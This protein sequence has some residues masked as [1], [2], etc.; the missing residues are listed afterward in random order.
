DDATAFE[1]YFG[2]CLMNG[3][4]MVDQSY[5]AAIAQG[6]VD[7][8]FQ[9]LFVRCGSVFERQQNGDAAATF[10]GEALP[11][12]QSG[13]FPR[14]LAQKVKKMGAV[15]FDQTMFVDYLTDE[16]G[17]CS[18]GVALDLRQGDLHVFRAKAVIMAMGY[19]C[20]LA[21]WYPHP[22][23]ICGPESTGDANAILMNHGIGVR[24]FELQVADSAA[25]FPTVGRYTMGMSLEPPNCVDA[26]NSEGEHYQKD[27]YENTPNVFTS[28]NVSILNAG[29][30]FNG[31][32]HEHRGA[33]LEYPGDDKMERFYR[34]T[35]EQWKSHFGYELPERIE[36]TP[37]FWSSHA[38]PKLD[39]T[40][41]TQVPGLY[42]AASAHVDGGIKES[43]AA[44]HIAG[45]NA[46]R[47]AASVAQAGVIKEDVDRILDHIYDL[48]EREPADGISAAKV[49]RSIQIAFGEGLGIMRDEAGM[50]AALEEFKRIRAEDLP[51]MRVGNKTRS[52]N[53]GWRHAI[54]AEYMLDV[55]IAVAMA[56]L[57]RKETR[58]F[59]VRTDYLETDVEN[60]NKQFIV[61]KEGDEFALSEEATEMSIMDAQT[62]WAS[63]PRPLNLNSYEEYR[64]SKGGQ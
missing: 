51:R 23:S 59:P 46:A 21:G 25:W 3:F 26:V 6:M 11:T 43:L 29:E 62:Y 35:R 4:A 19:Y 50:T 7:M 41:Q 33:W 39:T 20:W 18:G 63:F 55:A 30:Y 54:E 16:E 31:R 58:A 32:G 61:T 47:R 37:E 57:E 34:R 2:A 56:S 24:N 42:Y 45:V 13:M 28:I 5:T 40:M 8:K 36:T 53:L 15:V 60:Y 48:L 17:S 9:K 44:G 10:N 52:F 1:S 64:K 14:H 12:A 49:M 22:S 27:F 38:I